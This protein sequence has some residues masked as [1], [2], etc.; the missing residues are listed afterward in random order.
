MAGDRCP[1]DQ[2]SEQGFHLPTC[3]PILEIFPKRESVFAIRFP[4]TGEGIA[5]SSL[6][7]APHARIDLAL[8][9][10]IMHVILTAIVV[11]RWFGVLRYAEQ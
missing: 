7:L 3:Y 1:T 8:L 9:N 10:S 5:A 11:Q 6:R 2:V 4:E